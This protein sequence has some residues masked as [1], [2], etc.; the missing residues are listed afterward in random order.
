MGHY[1]ECRE[2]YCG[3]CGQTEGN[4]EHTKHLKKANE[5]KAV[6]ISRDEIRLLYSTLK[7]YDIRNQVRDMAEELIRYY[8]ADEKPLGSVK[9]DGFHYDVPVLQYECTACGKYFYADK[10][11][12]YCPNC[13]GKFEG[14]TK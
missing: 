8:D 9:T 6:V 3:R 7:K 14:V 5:E 11:Y 1:D 10:I 4:C 13:G 12:E 2:G